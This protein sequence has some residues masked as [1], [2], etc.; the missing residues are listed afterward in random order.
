MRRETS[1]EWGITADEVAAERIAQG[2]PPTLTDP[3]LLA[4]L[5]SFL[6]SPRANRPAA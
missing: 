1:P 6:R 2:L 3:E 5:A 4:M